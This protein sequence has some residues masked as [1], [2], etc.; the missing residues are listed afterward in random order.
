MSLAEMELACR[1]IQLKDQY[2]HDLQA[3][4]FQVILTM[5]EFERPSYESLFEASPKSDRENR[6]TITQ[7]RKHT[8][9][10]EPCN[11]TAAVRS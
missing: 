8:A 5:A 9:H 7:T 10:A 1:K 3:D 11:T 4:F 6:Y 2:A